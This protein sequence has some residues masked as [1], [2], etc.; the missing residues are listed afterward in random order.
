MTLFAALGEVAGRR[1]GRGLHVL[2]RGRDGE[3]LPYTDLFAEAGRVAAGLLSRGVEP[4]ERVALV[5]PTSVDFA[6]QLPRNPSGKLLKRQLREPYW[7]GYTRRI[8]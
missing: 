7:K 3:F 1:S 5:L 4:G 8:N 2:R 6:D